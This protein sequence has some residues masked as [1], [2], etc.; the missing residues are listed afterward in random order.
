MRNGHRI[1]QAAI[2]L[3]VGLVLAACGGNS[4]GGGGGSPTGGGGGGSPSA[5]GAGTTLTMQN[6]A[7]HPDT[8]T[9]GAGEQVTITVTNKDSVLH[10]FTMDD[11]SVAQD[12]QPGQTVDVT[13]TWPSS[14]SAGFHCRIHATMTGMLTVG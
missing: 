14:G 12:V 8:L 10:S 7:Y 4:S 11:G 1:A 5:G 6:I 13:V 2:V 3:A 9:A